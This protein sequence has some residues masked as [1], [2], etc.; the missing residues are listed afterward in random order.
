MY[1][2]SHWDYFCYAFC[3]YELIFQ[4]LEFAFIIFGFKVKGSICD[5]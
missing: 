1:E 4:F 5:I 3:V 2:K